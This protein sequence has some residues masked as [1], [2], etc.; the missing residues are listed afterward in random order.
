VP[1]DQDVVERAHSRHDL[2]VLERACES[3]ID[4]AV[5]ARRDH[6][7]GSVVGRHHHVAA[8]GAV[9]PGH[10]VDERRLAG[11]VGPDQREDLAVSHVER[12]VAQHAVTSEGQVHAV[13]AERGRRVG[14]WSHGRVPSCWVVDEATRL[15]SSLDPR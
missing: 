7:H 10:D 13:D 9:D 11:S 15:E 6:R 2:E 1:T 4:E 5:A 8:L 3:V 14:H 12:D